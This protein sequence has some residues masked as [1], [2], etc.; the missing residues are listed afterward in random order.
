MLRT[1]LR[2]VSGLSVQGGCASRELDALG[3][4]RRPERR[5][6]IRRPAVR[7]GLTWLLDTQGWLGATP[8]ESQLAR[9]RRQDWESRSLRSVAGCALLRR[10]FVAYWRVSKRR[11]VRSG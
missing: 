5:H 6:A 2:L 8:G 9:R 7:V 10:R 11:L 3:E 1:R 4:H